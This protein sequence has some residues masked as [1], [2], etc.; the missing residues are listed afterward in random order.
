MENCKSCYSVEIENQKTREVP[1]Y[2]FYRMTVSTPVL[3]SIRMIESSPG[4]QPSGRSRCFDICECS[5][6][7]HF[8]LKNSSVH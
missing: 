5:S 6:T 4:F 1:G 7:L 2:L 3:L 8:N